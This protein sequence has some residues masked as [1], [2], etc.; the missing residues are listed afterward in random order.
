MPLNDLT[1]INS[2]KEFHLE[3][4][5]HLFREIQSKKFKSLIICDYL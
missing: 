2:D 5:L 3:I 1:Y 4:F